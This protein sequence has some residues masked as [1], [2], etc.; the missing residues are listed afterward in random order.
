MAGL[1]QFY[2]PNAGYAAELLER[3]RQAPDSVAPADRALVDAWDSG[4]LPAADG[5]MLGA[6]VSAA[7][8]AAALAQAI[9][10]YGHRAAR[11]DPLGSDP[12][13]DPQI[14]A[15]AHGALESEL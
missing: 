4:A 14:E 2:G 8:A 12:P 1:D 9:R 11:L 13:G 7:A 6:D 10:Q 3:Y 15:D 5:V